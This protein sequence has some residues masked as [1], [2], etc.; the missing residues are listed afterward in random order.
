MV[1]VDGG[2]A[3]LTSGVALLEQAVGYTLGTLRYAA[4]GT[5]S[6]PSPCAGW[7][8]QAL[9]EHMI[10]SFT[11][12]QEAAD[13]GEV[14]LADVRDLWEAPVADPVEALRDRASALL[15][16]W[17]HCGDLVTIAGATLPSGIVAGAGAVEIAVHGWDVGQSCGRPEPIPAPLAQ[18]L[19][20]VVPSLVTD[21]DRPGRFAKPRYTSAQASL[22]DRLVAYLGRRP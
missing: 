3:T 9:L 16:A 14:E 15:G 21:A 5:L 12:L 1:G 8:L 18:A 4:P 13:A 20:S 22:G 7:D 17:T 6:Q 10:D 19:L 11:A 2:S